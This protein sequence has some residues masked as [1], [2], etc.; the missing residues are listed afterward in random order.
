MRVSY[1]RFYQW[2][3]ADSLLLCV[4]VCVAQWWANDDSVTGRTIAQSKR[5]LPF[6]PSFLP[7]FLSFLSLQRVAMETLFFFLHK[8]KKERKKEICSTEVLQVSTCCQI[9]SNLLQLR[10]AMRRSYK[11]ITTRTRTR[12]RTRIAWS[13][14]IIIIVYL[15]KENS[16]QFSRFCPF[17][18][19]FQ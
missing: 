5:A 3:M 1:G 15:L 9:L 18:L 16:L 13:G 19:A 6:L 12:T 10:H 4:C 2:P 11:N 7:F 17:L 14:F 8:R